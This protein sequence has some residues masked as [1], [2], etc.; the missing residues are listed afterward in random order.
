MPVRAEG[1]LEAVRRQLLERSIVLGE[2]IGVGS[3]ATVFEGTDQKHGRRVAIKVLDPEPGIDHQSERFAREIRLIAQFSHPNIFPLY[4]SGEAAGIHY[5]IMPLAN[6]Q[7]LRARLREGP[8][9]PEEVVPLARE[10]ADALR[11]AHERGVIHRDVKPGNILLE[12]R[13]AFIADFGLAESREALVGIGS[14]DGG[15]FTLSGR[16]VGTVEYMA[17]EQ[18][19][20]GVI[21]ERSDLY[22]L[23]CT[24]YE[25][26]TGTLPFGADSAAETA[27]RK[28]AGR[29]VP[30][31]QVASSVPAPLA[32]L[33]DGML[34]AD[35]ANRPQSAEQ[36]LARLE[37]LLTPSS[38]GRLVSSQATWLKRGVAV[39]SLIG[40][41]V[42]IQYLFAD[43]LD[44]DRVVVSTFTNETGDPSLDPF[45]H[46]ASDWIRD[47]L[48][49]AGH[50]KVIASPLD[51]PVTSARDS[52]EV[53]V[54][55]TRLARLAR[56]THSGRVILGS[57]YLTGDRL[58]LQVEIVAASTGEVEVAIGPI[59]SPRGASDQ[60][61]SNGAKLV[62]HAIDSLTTPSPSLARATKG[63]RTGLTG[64]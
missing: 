62:A 60:L 44:P 9:K 5:Y 28:L 18:L 56:E 64:R 63:G 50:I 10:L 49:E 45:G 33:V 24:L 35:P 19:V 15:R 16:F 36:V 58:E 3:A 53:G 6:G 32:D 29:F 21:D 30:L 41:G 27:R 51:L 17:P 25:S 40:A 55:P 13:H 57:Y 61:A 4:D 8:L 59:Q 38:A 11:Y 34:A 2:Q 7:S 14:S 26:L 46:Q 52:V 12:G 43:R 23:G 1:G 37:P 42:S 39:L 54:T 22:A 47:A 48:A 31:R 20:G